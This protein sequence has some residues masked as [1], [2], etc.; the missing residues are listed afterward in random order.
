[1]DTIWTV[2]DLHKLRDMAITRQRIAAMLELTDRQVRHLLARPGDTRLDVPRST[3]ALTFAAALG[4][5]TD[6]SDAIKLEHRNEWKNG[7]RRVRQE[8]ATPVI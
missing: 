5:P 1:M 3:D 7:P 6:W 2:H 4:K 8:I